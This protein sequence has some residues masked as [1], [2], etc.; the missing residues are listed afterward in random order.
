MIGIQDLARALQQM[1]ANTARA[2]KL[3]AFNGT[4][5]ATRGPE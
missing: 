3:A 4:A 1:I 5:D 2:W